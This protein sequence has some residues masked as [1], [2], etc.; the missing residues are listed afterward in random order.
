[1]QELNCEHQLTKV[2]AE[3]KIPYTIEDNC[4]II[5]DDVSA[6][7]LNSIVS[8]FGTTYY[9]AVDKRATMIVVKDELTYNLTDVEASILRDMVENMPSALILATYGIT[10][11]AYDWKRIKFATKEDAFAMKFLLLENS[12]SFEEA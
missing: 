9:R 10:Q 5:A 3:R 8:N 12:L 4:V 7:V 6:N 1:M 2:I 11:Q